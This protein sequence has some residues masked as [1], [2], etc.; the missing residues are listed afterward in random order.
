MKTK[1][2]LAASCLALLCTARLGAQSEPPL[3]LHRPPEWNISAGYGFSIHVNR[4]RSNEKVL[5]F[6]PGVAFRV[7]SR[8]EYLVEAHFARYVSP[9]GYMVGAMPIG[10]RLYLGSGRVLPYIS[11]GAGAGWTDLTELEEI[12]QR[13]NFLLQTS[14][15][16][17]RATSATAGW[18]LE[19]R[20][21]H[22]SNAGLARPNLGLNMLVF[23]GGWRFR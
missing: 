12:D 8:F 16:V 15:G 23:L 3:P 2:I 17:R 21:S 4:G 11:L 9:G 7:G 6:D 20:W 18:T 10:A 1:V 5:L 19:A 22:I 14:L 13:F